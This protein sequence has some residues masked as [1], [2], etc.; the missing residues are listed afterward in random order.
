MI[1]DHRRLRMNQRSDM[2]DQSLKQVRPRSGVHHYRKR[3]AER[4]RLSHK[5]EIEPELLKKYFRI[6]IKM[7][8]GG[9]LVSDQPIS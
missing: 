1:N 6:N 2:K 8:C 9:G 3:P 4:Q 7:M 5:L